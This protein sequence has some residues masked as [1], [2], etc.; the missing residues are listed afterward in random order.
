LIIKLL[1][2]FRSRKSITT[3]KKKGINFVKI[4][5]VYIGRQF[6]DSGSI[7]DNKGAIELLQYKLPALAGKT[8]SRATKL[9]T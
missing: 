6:A 1:K 3:S 9:V 4:T 7:L 5:G 2:P 8:P